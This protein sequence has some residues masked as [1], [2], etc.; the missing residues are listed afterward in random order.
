MSFND[1]VGSSPKDD[2]IIYYNPETFQMEWLAYT[3]T[4]YTQEKSSKF[5]YIRYD[6]W[7]DFNGVVLPKSLTWYRTNENGEPIE[8]R[9]T[10]NFDKIQ[11]VETA[12]AEDAFA[13]PANARVV[14]E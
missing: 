5:G 6:D 4:Y 10:V 14:T 7:S 9:N 11:L 2:Y 8:P 13:M 12:P 3:A 1:G